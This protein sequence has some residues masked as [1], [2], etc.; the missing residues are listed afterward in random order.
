[1]F[2]MLFSSL[3]LLVKTLLSFLPEFLH[4]SPCLLFKIVQT[5]FSFFLPLK[6]HCKVIAY[7]GMP[8]AYNMNR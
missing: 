2:V 8:Y 7:G 5:E 1:M 3:D 6:G 4:L